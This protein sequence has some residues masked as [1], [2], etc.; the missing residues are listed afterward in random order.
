MT[1]PHPPCSP[2]GTTGKRRVLLAHCRLRN[3]PRRWNVAHRFS[4]IALHAEGRSHALCGHHPEWGTAFLLD[5]NRVQSIA[6]VPAAT[7]LSNGV[8]TLRRGSTL[9]R[10]RSR[11]PGF[12]GSH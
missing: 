10:R 3:E 7:R 12:R 8:K 11:T 4:A 6:A 2:H 9:R 5:P 1:M